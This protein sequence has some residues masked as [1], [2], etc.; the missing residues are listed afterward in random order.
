MMDTPVRAQHDATTMFRDTQVLV[1]QIFLLLPLAYFA[2][3]VV[4]QLASR[5][6]YSAWEQSISELGVT[7]SGTF[8]N[9]ITKQSVYID[10]PLHAVMN[11][12]FVLYGV[13]V[14][15]GV[16]CAIRPMWPGRHLRKF[17]LVLVGLCGPALIL[18]GLS[19]GDVRPTLHYIAGG[20]QFPAQNTGLILLGFAA[21]RTRPGLGWFTLLCGIVGMTGL[22]FQGRPPHVGL[23]Y[24]GWQRVAAYPSAIW[25]IS[26]GVYSLAR[27]IYAKSSAAGP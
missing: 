13:G 4:A 18:V 21:I 9:P 5:A 26:I 12:A 10:S 1:G 7:T 2:G 14:L 27:R 24:G 16:L 25:A 19:P 23:G 8:T 20:Y 15:V 22:I 11:S 6:P 3:Q 17:G